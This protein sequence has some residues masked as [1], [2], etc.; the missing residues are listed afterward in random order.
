MATRAIDG[1]TDTNFGAKSCTVTGDTTTNPWWQVA[2]P[3]AHSIAAIEITNR[4]DCC[5]ERL[6]GFNVLVD[7]RKCASNVQIKQGE[8]KTVP[9]EATG[10]VVKVELPGRSRTL[11]I[12]E[13]RVVRHGEFPP[14]AGQLC[15]A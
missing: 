8:T 2:L 6:N 11:T 7:G 15:N 10:K 14:F 12:C 9:C 13:L 5:G 1:N 4:G 3:K